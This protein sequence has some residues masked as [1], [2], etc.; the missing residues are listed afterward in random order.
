MEFLGFF[1]RHFRPLA[2]ISAVFL[3]A[4]T[5]LAAIAWSKP[6]AIEQKT[7]LLNYYQDSRFDYLVTLTPSTIFADEDTYNISTYNYPRSITESLDFTFTHSPSSDKPVSYTVSAVM[8]NRG[9][10]EKAYQLLPPVSQQGDYTASFSL[11]IDAYESKF[12]TFEEALGINGVR[13]IRIMVTATSDQQTFVFS[14]PIDTGEDLIKI[15]SNLIQRKL[16]G[17]GVF[18]YAVNL[19]PNPV[20]DSPVILSPQTSETTGSVVEPGDVIFTRMADT[21]D[22]NYQYR[23]SDNDGN[24]Q[25]ETITR[26]SL[27]L[28]A[29]K[30]WNHEIPLAEVA[31]D[32]NA[33]MNFN[34]DLA[35]FIELMGN[36]KSETGV[37]ADNYSLVLKAE[38]ALNADTSH[39]DISETYLHTLSGTINGGILTW[40]DSLTSQTNGSITETH[41]VD[42]PAR[43]A[44][45]TATAA[46]WLFLIFA[47]LALACLAGLVFL[48]FKE[49]PSKTLESKVNSY[50]K[51][52]GDRIVDAV[53]EFPIVENMVVS[54]GSMEELASVSDE[55]AK[56]IVYVGP[57]GNGLPHTFYVLDGTTRY[58]FLLN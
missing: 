12:G 19:K 22:I 26:L 7:P 2:V 38:T 6:T 36:I 1:Y 47:L 14:L 39:G 53:S 49:R 11:D 48:Y 34:L 18:S 41:V 8:E 4:C 50:H 42:N 51:K 28:T 44:G 3:V 46:R 37:P 5:A 57:L 24:S 35:Y 16:C 15:N 13:F 45:M 33:S 31:G 17:R 21:M 23:Y 54:L 20:F 30:L 9:V 58:Q 32:K 25:A 56:P 43:V 52:Y 27:V 55:L 10:W 40:D 29:G